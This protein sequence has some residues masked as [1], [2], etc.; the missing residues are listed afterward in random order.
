MENKLCIKP[1]NPTTD[2]IE[3]E[4]TVYSGSLFREWGCNFPD[5]IGRH[6]MVIEKGDG[7][8]TIKEFYDEK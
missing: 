7:V 1:Y 3:I 8:V 4:G 6:L 5:L 2:T